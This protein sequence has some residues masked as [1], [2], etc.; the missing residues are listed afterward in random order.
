M[1][2]LSSNLDVILDNQT[3]ASNYLTQLSYNILINYIQ[4][5]IKINIGILTTNDLT[6]DNYNCYQNKNIQQTVD[7]L[8]ILV[9]DHQ[10]D[11]NI[12]HDLHCNIP[13]AILINDYLTCRDNVVY[14]PLWLLAS[15]IFA[16]ADII[17]D[18]NKTY[19]VSC[20]NR[21][22]RP[23]RIYNFIKLKNLPFADELYLTC[24]KKY[25][26]GGDYL[27]SDSFQGLDQIDIDLFLEIYNTLPDEL[28]EYNKLGNIVGEF[29]IIEEI[30]TIAYT[31][32]MLNV[33]TETYCNHSFLSEKTFKPIRAEQLFL[34]SGPM[35]SIK[36]LREFGFDTFN[37]YIDHDYYDSEPNWQLRIL[38]MHT[39]LQSIYYDID[40][41]YQKTEKRR[42]ENRIY[43]MSDRLTHLCTTPLIN[44]IK[45]H[46]LV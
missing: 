35:H 6:T 13:A 30:N 18:G 22:P 4:T 43:L 3:I 24:Y 12:V 29:G 26:C 27:D 45:N 39:I 42:K 8:F 11:E 10:F 34:M 37:D 20:I 15:K 23:G 33:I 2:F 46:E 7:V 9:G 14:F 31:D 19:K 38:K 25:P 16:N 36:K 40:S 44:W 5:D 1:N 17:A 28:I 41:I 32:S 21:N